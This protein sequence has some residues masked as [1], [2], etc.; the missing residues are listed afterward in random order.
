MFSAPGALFHRAQ[1]NCKLKATR[2]E[3]VRVAGMAPRRSAEATGGVSALHCE[4]DRQ[5]RARGVSL[6]LCGL[7]ASSAVRVVSAPGPSSGTGN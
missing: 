4:A 3:S 7:E 6:V 1:R 5:S 2:G